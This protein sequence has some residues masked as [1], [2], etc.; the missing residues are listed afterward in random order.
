MTPAATAS[1][2]ARLSA[3]RAAA[4]AFADWDAPAY[5]LPED[6]D[7]AYA[8]QA[9]IIRLSGGPVRGW[10]V[11]ALKREDQGAYGGDRP[12]AGPLLA[13]AVHASPA[14]LPLSGFLTPMLECEFAFVLGRD[15]PPRSAPYDLDAVAQAVDAVVAAFEIADGRVPAG[16]PGPLRLADSM[17]NGAFVHGVPIRDWRG[18][19]RA[20]P[21]VLRLDGAVVEE[22]S[23]RRILGDPLKAVQALANAQPLAGSLRAGQMITTGTATMPLRLTRP[24]LAQADFGPLGTIAVA[25][26]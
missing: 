15:L 12:V 25:I 14:T 1:L 8:V 3:A 26:G 24:G 18:L 7:A 17:G 5:A 23:G 9:E 2:A 20:G 4:H 13:A 6:P 10:K 22:G 11:T 21:V 16:A 19:D